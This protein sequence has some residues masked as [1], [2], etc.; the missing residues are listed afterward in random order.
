MPQS[1]EEIREA[2]GSNPPV[3]VRTKAHG[4]FGVLQLQA[5]LGD[6]LHTGT[7]AGRP[8]DPAWTIR[9]LV[10]FRPQTWQALIDIAAR[11]STPRRRVS[12]GQVAATLLEDSVTNL[13]DISLPPT[14]DPRPD[15]R[16][17]NRKRHAS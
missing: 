12:P 15:T 1:P 4:P 13:R 2:L 17:R 8:S 7:K 9:R 3:S 16:S 10:G 6:R 11:L 14:G 5:E